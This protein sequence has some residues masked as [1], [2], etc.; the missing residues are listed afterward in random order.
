MDFM[1]D[2]LYSG[3]SIRLLTIVD[4]YS[5]ESLALQVGFRLG[6]NDVVQA[7]NR[8]IA[9]RGIP[10]G[11]HAD[12]SVRLDNGPE[13]TSRVLDHW[14]WCN[15][16]TLDFI[17]LGTLGGAD[18]RTTTD[19][20]ED[21]TNPM[22]DDG[23]FTPQSIREAIEHYARTTPE[24]TCL[25]APGRQRLS[26]A[27]LSSHVS[28]TREALNAAGAGRGDRVAVVL[29]SGPEMTAAYLSVSASATFAPLNPAYPQSEYEFYL[30]DLG[31]KVLVTRA[32]LDCPARDVAKR[33]GM[34]VIELV[35]DEHSPAGL[36]ELRSDSESPP[37]APGPACPDDVA[38][39]L[40]TSGTT[41][42]PKIVPLT[43]RK[44]CISA[45]SVRDSLH[46][47]AEDRL[48]SVMPMFHLHGLLASTLASLVSGGAL[49]ATPGFHAPEFF[50]WVEQ[51]DP[52][53]YTA[54]PTMHQAI[55]E[56]AP[57]NRELIERCR[58]RVIRSSSAA[59]PIEVIT[60][61]EEAFAVPLIEVYG[62]TE[63]C[64][65]VTS[66]PLPPGVRKPGSVGVA[67]TPE[68]AIIDEHRRF[69]PP[70]TRGEIVARGEIIMDGYDR[71]PEANEEAFFDGWFR[72]GD[73]G[74][75]DEDGYFYISGRIK[76]IIIRGGENISPREVDEVLITHPDIQQ[77]L[78]FA[79]P[80][81]RLGEDVAAAV[82]LR[83]GA[84]TSPM[85]IR[86]YVA[87]QVAG[88][89]VPREVVIV[90]D[91]P[92]TATGK[93]KRIGMAEALGLIGAEES[94]QA[95]HVAPRNELED[96]LAG[97][98]A[99]VLGL[100]SVGVHDRFL[101]LGGDSVLA[102]Q[103]AVRVRQA[104]DVEFSLLRF[105]GE[106]TVAAQAALLEQLMDEEQG[107]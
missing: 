6:G 72:T 79:I 52:T 24:A 80:D 100:E 103:I 62:T 74:Y 86:E 63:A 43:H 39:V 56:R 40:H 2:Q 82:V 20:G 53:W 92:T 38:L 77:A 69:L 32:D 90:D 81:P 105:F 59:L 36:F 61:L 17:R 102:T 64:Q 54:V 3:R 97:I 15:G 12:A 35:A 94:T 13:F 21:T 23:R 76:E 83:D 75:M 107:E 22:R 9:D 68:V 78:T 27:D 44:L 88:H 106:P 41:A 10:D 104:L 30:G 85:A 95:D 1:S 89:K 67:L 84:T 28:R 96:A 42:R 34:A 65:N 47:T 55:V 66:N 18:L 45:C 58:I 51:F 25:L 11:I 73:E 8:L 60:R 46:L 49:V 93:L 98:W 16:V 87:G 31:A 37:D 4:N 14:A 19:S 91:I 7:L 5:R 48:L 70:N 71:N 99:T 26:Y 57:A 29:P 33:M 50:A 101:A